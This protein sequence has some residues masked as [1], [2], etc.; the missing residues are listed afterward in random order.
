[1]KL[2]DFDSNKITYNKPK[3]FKAMYLSKSLYDNNDI[4][5]QLKRKVTLSG[6]YR[7]GNKYY[8]DL[9]FD[10]ENNK[11]RDFIQLYKKVEMLSIKEIY[12]KYNNWMGS[13]E[14]L[15]FEDIYSSFKSHLTE[16][17]NIKRVR[18]SL[19]TT[20]NMM[21]TEFYNEK[22]D[23]VSYKE[24]EEGDELSLVV[25]FDGIKFGKE[26]FE[27]YW[28]VLQVKI[29][30]KQESSLEMEQDLNENENENKNFK[31]INISDE[32]SIELENDQESSLE[33]DN[34]EDL[35]K[36]DLN[37]QQKYQKYREEERLKIIE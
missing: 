17:N 8:V 4:N 35:K 23:K 25:T 29:Y 14:T 12:K 6:V 19:M 10:D 34:I 32:E 15:E 11:D 3:K 22:L 21:D 16:E 31:F 28:K 13:E 36:L 18:F 24:V 27:N 9:L 20:K 37:I 2:T 33:I 30:D 7:E 1:M 5:I 26:K